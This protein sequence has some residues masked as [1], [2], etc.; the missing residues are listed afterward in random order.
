MELRSCSPGL[1]GPCCAGRFLPDICCSSS[2][3]WFTLVSMAVPTLYA[4][5]GASR[6]RASTFARYIPDVDVVA[7]LLSGTVDGRDLLGSQIS[8]EDCYDPS[9]TVGVLTRTVDVRVSQRRIGDA[10][11]GVVVVQAAFRCQLRDAIRR[12]RAF[13]DGLPKRGTRPARRRP[14]RRSRRRL[15]VPLHTSCSFVGGG[16]SRGH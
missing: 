15:L 11:L 8:G 10:V 1:A 16:S 2:Y 4:P 9:L 14:L 7:R 5:E 13:G 6:S 12:Y 3:S